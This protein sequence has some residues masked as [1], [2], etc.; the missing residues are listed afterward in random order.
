M[1]ASREARRC[2]AGGAYGA[3]LL[4]VLE[5]AEAGD[6]LANGALTPT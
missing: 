1:A 3:A 2:T 5:A 6:R 4:N